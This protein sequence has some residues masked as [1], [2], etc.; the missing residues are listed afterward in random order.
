MALG[1]VVLGAALAGCSR[2][3]SDPSGTADTTDAT[4]TTDGPADGDTGA[5]AARAAAVAVRA[6][7][8]RQGEALTGSGS[9]VGDGLVVT[10]AHVV[11]GSTAVTV[12][13]AAG[14]GRPGS[15]VALDTVNDLALVAVDGLDVAPLPLGDLAAG[16]R[17]VFV[18]L[19][20]G[21]GRARI[22]PVAVVRRVDLSMA[23]L[24]GQGT[25]VRP[26]FE[27]E[28]AVDPGDSGAMVVGGDGRAGAV[29][30]AA[31]RDAAVGSTPGRD[32][33][34][35]AWATDIAALVPLLARVD[36]ATPVPTGPCVG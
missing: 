8:C 21:G 30:F 23:A 11:A 24:Y 5:E 22:E 7:G 20:P 16:D 27:I 33:G 15:V 34:P 3:P 6:T 13:D 18:V 36:A 1:A 14:S 10:V 32:D 26:G 17:G 4:G 19:D 35:R 2:T 28:A 25:H 29:I 31:G 12:T 9:V